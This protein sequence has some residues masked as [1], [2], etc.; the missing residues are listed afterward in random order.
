MFRSSENLRLAAEM[1]ALQRVAAP[2]RAARTTWFDGTPESIAARLAAT[3]RVLTFARAGYTTAHMALER[4]AA[5]A[6]AELKEASHRLLVDFLDD[7]ARAFKGSKRV[8][9]Y[10]PK[11]YDQR[12]DF[13][14]WAGLPFGLSDED[15]DYD[16][17]KHLTSD[18]PKSKAH[19][20]DHPEVYGDDPDWHVKRSSR[21]V[22]GE[23][24]YAREE[25]EFWR[26]HVDATGPGVGDEDEGWQTFDLPGDSFNDKH[27]WLMKQL[28]RSPEEAHEARDGHYPPPSNFDKFVQSGELPSADSMREDIARWTGKEGGYRLAERGLRECVNCGG[29][30]SG[31]EDDDDDA[32]CGT[33]GKSAHQKGVDWRKGSLHEAYGRHNF[34]DEIDRAYDENRGRLDYPMV[35]V[36]T[37]GGGIYRNHPGMIDGYDE[38]EYMGSEYGYDA[39]SDPNFVP[40]EYLGPAGRDMGG[41]HRAEGSFHTAAP[42]DEACEDCGAECGED[43]RPWCCGKAKHDEEKD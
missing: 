35:N 16:E 21:R 7:G 28:G 19:L 27:D 10:D 15:P 24:P 8:A 1:R 18:N 5:A 4:E 11:E 38:G 3:E 17:H 9:D 20:Y 42:E 23:D 39:S 12:Q 6:R 37:A 41:K 22:A 31:E 25:R 32:E 30:L 34:E 36:D 13:M 14:D 29:S 43:C 26:K 40:A 33:C 2:W